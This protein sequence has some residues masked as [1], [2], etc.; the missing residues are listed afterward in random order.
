MFPIFSGTSVS[1]VV[2]EEINVAVKTPVSESLQDVPKKE[3]LVSNIKPLTEPLGELEEIPELQPEVKPK[4]TLFKFAIAI[5][6]V[7]ISSII[8]YF[9]LM[10]YKKISS[11]TDFGIDAEENTLNAPKNFKEAINLFLRKTKK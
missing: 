7:L 9:S 3:I 1:A 8:I 10:S 4:S 11:R 6:W 5:L 2:Q